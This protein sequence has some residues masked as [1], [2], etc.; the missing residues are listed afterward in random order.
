MSPLLKGKFLNGV[1]K[2]QATET[3]LPLAYCLLFLF[4][5]EPVVTCIIYLHFNV[6]RRWETV[7]VLCRFVIL[8][9]DSKKFPFC[10]GDVT[11]SMPRR[12]INNRKI[13]QEENMKINDFAIS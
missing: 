10:S 2:Y 4:W 11:I 7:K 5:P 12:L 6:N 3:G 13:F 1:L 8:Q 9:Q